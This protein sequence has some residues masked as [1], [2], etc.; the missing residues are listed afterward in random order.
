MVR[1]KENYKP[2]KLTVSNIL[3]ES[4]AYV[5]RKGEDNR[6]K[7]AWNFKSIQKLRKCCK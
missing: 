4:N 7:I 1:G 6:P 5:D 2:N 3:E